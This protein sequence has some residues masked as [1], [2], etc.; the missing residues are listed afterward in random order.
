M[1]ALWAIHC[2]HMIKKK[3]AGGLLVYIRSSITALCRSNLKSA[4]IESICLD[5][6]SC[7]NSWFLICA[8][9]QSLWKCKVSKFLPP[10]A[11]LAEKMY[12]KRKEII[13]IGDFNIDM[14]SE[15]TSSGWSHNLT[16]FCDKFCL[17]N[18]ITDHTT[19]T[20]SSKPLLDIILV[21]HPDCFAASGTLSLGISDNDLISS[22]TKQ[23]CQNQKQGLLNFDHFRLLM[24][25]RFLQT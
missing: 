10:V 23:S 19:V 25:R 15:K 4:G 17:T 11:E 24:K 14:P 21:S 13:F 16:N 5:V 1:T 3:G 9:Y 6:K 12:T 22:F 7:L 8:C 2:R 18:T 20:V